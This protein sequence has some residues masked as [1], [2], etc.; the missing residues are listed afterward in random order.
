[1]EMSKKETETKK[2]LHEAETQLA[3]TQRAYSV[4]MAK[5]GHGLIEM[6][7]KTRK[8]DLVLSLIDRIDTFIYTSTAYL[9]GLK[10]LLAVPDKIQLGR[11]NRQHFIQS[12]LRD[13]TQPIVDTY[14]SIWK[15]IKDSLEIKDFE[16]LFP[17]RPTSFEAPYQAITMIVGL[18][19]QLVQLK[20][21]LR[22]YLFQ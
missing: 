2:R 12:V 21:Y 5:M 7:E 13:P 15:D 17:E 1:M 19:E 10:N 18:G 4:A 14:K 11:L 16:E 9:D 6:I 22:R 8:R 3:E 20:R